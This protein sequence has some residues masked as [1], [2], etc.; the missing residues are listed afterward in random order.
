[1]SNHTCAAYMRYSSDN[2]QETSIEY[3]RQAIEKYCASNDLPLLAEYIDRAQSATT[4][5]RTDFQR[6]ME[7]ARNK[8]A[9]D[10]IIVYDLSRFSRNVTDASNYACELLSHGIRLISATE[11]LDDSAESTLVRNIKFAFNQYFSDHNA[12]V[13]HGGQMA[14]AVK[15][16]HCGGIPPLGY[17]IENGKLVINEDE[18]AIVQ[19][20]FNMFL[21]G[22][23]YSHM[24]KLLNQAGHTTKAGRPFN[25]NSFSGILHQEKYTGLFVWNRSSPKFRSRKKGRDY[26][27]NSHRSKPID[28]QVRIE[29]G[30]PAIISTE[31]YQQAQELLASRAHG[32]A[33]TKSRRYYLLGGMGILKCGVCSRAMV[34]VPRKDRH[35]NS[36]TT[37]ACPNHKGKNAIC[38]TKEIKTDVV[39]KLVIKAI[40]ARIMPEEWYPLIAKA[41]QQSS[42]GESLSRKKYGVEKKISNLTRSLEMQF[43]QTLVDRLSSLEAE[44]ARLEA[45]LQ[46]IQQHTFTL[47]QQNFKATRRKLL[48]Y[49]LESDS[50]EARA[51]LKSIIKEVRI[52]NNNIS[53]TLNIT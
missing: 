39:D 7:D 40:V 18:A 20:I 5:C 17:D 16:N 24:A 22:I 23:S 29:G 48:H 13:T 52:D 6:M 50:A 3:Q 33:M 46:H 25:K 1:M 4:D 14:Q 34:G 47:T 41:L 42:G 27:W 51:L 38:P 37:Y 31:Q 26:S 43:S 53:F 15:A 28:E 8:P 49:L 19:E 12:E 44:K 21:N 11:P 9:W 35:G 32:N 10:T 45:Q 2:Q 30:C 36:Y